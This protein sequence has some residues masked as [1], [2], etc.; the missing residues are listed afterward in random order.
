M[1]QFAR[2]SVCGSLAQTC[3]V[4]TT[5]VDIPTPPHSHTRIQS[6]K[7]LAASWCS[8]YLFS[9][10]RLFNTSGKFCFVYRCTWEIV[11]WFYLFI[12]LVPHIN[13]DSVQMLPGARI[14]RNNTLKPAFPCFN[15][16]LHWWHVREE[17]REVEGQ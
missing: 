1:G 2:P 9:F 13:W 6:I 8:N 10:L 4:K 3:R 16:S 5:F 11:Y 15:Y 17:E 14:N 7:Y 12:F